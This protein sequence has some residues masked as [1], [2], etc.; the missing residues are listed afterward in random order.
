[1]GNTSTSS[2]ITSVLLGIP[3]ETTVGKGAGITD[4]MYRQKTDA[5]KRALE[6]N[7]PDRNDPIDVVAKVGG[8]DI[9]GLI[10]VYLACAEERVPVIIDGFI[11]AT[12]AL[13]ASR[14]SADAVGFM[15]PSH[16]SEEPA[17]KTIMT[18]MGLD[19]YLALDMRLGEG[20]GCPIAF[21]VIDCALAMENC[22]ATFA[23]ATIDNS[24][25][26]DIREDE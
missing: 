17:F 21:H 22:M 5:L 6:I 13:A 14:L 10:G 18:S 2:C 19:A 16:V 23:E 20:S 9:A 8:F 25:F 4:E 12:A 11:S 3:V 24:E 1:M 15:I 7:A 26:V